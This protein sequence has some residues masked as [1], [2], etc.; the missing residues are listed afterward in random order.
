MNQHDD[1][2][3]VKRS[4]PQKEVGKVEKRDAE[5]SSK[6]TGAQS[7]RRI[8]PDA[9]RIPDKGQLVPEEV[10]QGKARAATAEKNEGKLKFLKIPETYKSGN[11]DMV[12]LVI[13]LMLLAFGAVMSFSA[14][15]AYAS[16]KYGDSYY[17]LWRQL[18]Y[19]FIGMVAILMVTL[20]PLK[21]YRVGTY[22]IFGVAIILLLLVL[23]IGTERGGAKRW[24]EIPGLGSFQPSELAKTALVMMIAMYMAKFGDEVQSKSWKKAV[25][26]GLVFPGL[27]IL[28]IGGLVVAEKH[29]SGLVILCCIGFS[30]MVLGGSKLRY[31]V[32]IGAIAVV[33]IGAMIVFT[34]YSSTRIEV[35]LDP[36]TDPTGSGWQTIQGL[37]TIASGGIFGVGLGN[38]R[39]KFGYVAEPQ[40]DFIFTIVCEE[41]GFIGAMAVMA[42]FF[43]L[44]WRGFVIARHSPN[45]F[46]Y[47][48]VMGLMVKVALQVCFNIAVVTNS[49]PNTGISLPFFSSGGTS[50]V[51]QMA[52]MGI[53]LSISCYSH[54]KK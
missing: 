3:F 8:S 24:L 42:L 46:T 14:S 1:D 6:K 27:I 50:L 53:V 54:N 48:I 13:L 19:T 31:I 18:L 36:W 45:R 17:F 28:L 22:F 29:F 7:S 52:E 20:I 37:Y 16:T 5:N 35:W 15:Y 47:L 32:P 9:K 43:L 4:V 41:L 44:I 23:F 10:K 25:P 21:Y 49:I 30:V 12:F 26:Y 51:V 34:D 39:Q 11:V 38:S 2:F 33:A 40:N